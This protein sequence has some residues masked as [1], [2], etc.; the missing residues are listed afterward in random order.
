[1]SATGMMACYRIEPGAIVV[2]VRLTPRANRD[3]VDG[4]GILA[5]GRTVIQARVRAVPES[6]AA[7]KAL[8]MLLAKTFQRPKSAV[9]LIAGATTRIK[10]VRVT[11]DP[12]D[13]AA[14]VDGWQAKP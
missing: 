2:S 11:G 6:G 9:E 12:A 4:I 7:N 1:M 8:T 5:D 3:A 10:Q 13:L 14:V